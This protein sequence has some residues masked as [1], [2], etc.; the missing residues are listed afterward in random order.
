VDIM[1]GVLDY[2]CFDSYKSEPFIEVYSQQRTLVKLIIALL[3]DYSKIK[4]H[5]AK[6]EVALRGGKKKSKKASPV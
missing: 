6:L 3:G 5:Q 1:G 2:L 4:Q